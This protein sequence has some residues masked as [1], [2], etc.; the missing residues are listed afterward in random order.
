MSDRWTYKVVDVSPSMLGPTM[1]EKLS[2]ELNRLGKQGWELVS[3]NQ[4][5]PFDHVRLILKKDS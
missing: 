5:S 1:S 2:D 3:V 4:T